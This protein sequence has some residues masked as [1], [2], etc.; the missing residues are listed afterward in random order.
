MTKT[1][2]HIITTTICLSGFLQALVVLLQ[3]LHVLQSYSAYFDISGTFSN[4]GYAACILVPSVTVLISDLLLGIETKELF[5]TGTIIRL[6]GIFFLLY[7]IYVCNSRAAVLSIAV[8]VFYHTIRLIRRRQWTTIEHQCYIALLSVLS[9]II[10]ALVLYHIRPQSANGRLLIWRV[11]L[12]IIKRNPIF[13]I[14]HGNIKDVFMY[15]QANYFNH[16]PDSQFVLVANEYSN[17]FNEPIRILCEYG[18]IGLC[19]TCLVIWLIWKNSAD[20]IKAV[21]ISFV[22][23]SCFINITTLLPVNLMLLSIMVLGLSRMSHNNSVNV[24]IILLLSFWI[25]ACPFQQLHRQL[26]EDKELVEFKK[27]N[28]PYVY[29]CERGLQ[30]QEAGDIEKAEACF[31]LAHHMI[32]CRIYP[33]YLLFKLYEETEHPQVYQQA[34]ILLEQQVSIIGDATVR[35]R[36]EAKDFLRNNSTTSNEK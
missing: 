24:I 12:D 10:I 5:R 18:C 31:Q 4:P 16:H 19:I 33:S 7:A 3:R 23:L 34:R 2:Q 36:G 21:I 11:C 17:T 30:Y 6:L 20:T 28:S 35:M 8:V 15:A 13:G 27:R 25:L 32:P 1:I 14:G 22:I 9:F 26:C 29:C